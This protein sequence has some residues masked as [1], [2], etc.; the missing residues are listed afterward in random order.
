[1]G[2][3]RKSVALSVLAILAGC[4]SPAWNKPGATQAM[5]DADKSACEYEALK[6]AG[7]FD[8]SYRSAFGS[9]LDMAMRRNEIAKAC[10]G[11]KGWSVAPGGQASGGGVTVPSEPIQDRQDIPL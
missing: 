4:A 9:S 2:F 3:L 8:N 11:Q 10:M 1:M 6:Y 7:G 5:F